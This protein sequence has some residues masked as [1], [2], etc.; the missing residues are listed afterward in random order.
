MNKKVVPTKTLSR[1]EWLQ[2]RRTGIGGSDASVI[3]GINPWRSVFQLWE[4]K[5]GAVPLGDSG[6]EFTYWGNVM[7]PI[8]RREFMK[9]TG[10][11]VRQKHAMIFHPE[12]SYLFADLDGIVT[13]E[14]GEKCVFEAKT[15]SQYKED[16]WEEGVP[17][18]Y[19]LQVQHYLAVTGM[20]KAY[21][22][23]LI[24]GN[25]FVYRVLY[26]DEGLISELLGKEAEFWRCV[27]EGKAPAADAS[28]ATGAYLNEKYRT[29][30]EGSL[31]LDV[32]FGTVLEEYDRIRQD[33]HRLETE[34]DKIV[35]QI[36]AA[37]GHYEQGT[38]GERTISWKPVL[39]N[40]LDTKRLKKEKP[41]VYR[42][43]EKK[44]AYRRLT[45]A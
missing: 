2:L 19:V 17:Q 39:R 20:R 12:L 1:E 3:M 6:N 28:P 8:L 34:Q 24:G 21:I 26:R 27:R 22:A 40:S 41:E 36:K 33:I 14:T 43:Y 29:C 31:A 9:R 38:V 13:E 18:E 15:A 7:E 42:E 4:E 5:T 30:K 16:V 23:A 11:R 10:L 32:S 37:L 44:M 25:R 45:V 35:N